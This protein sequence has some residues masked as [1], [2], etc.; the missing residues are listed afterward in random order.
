MFTW[1]EYLGLDSVTYASRFWATHFRDYIPDVMIYSLPNALWYLSGMLV[2]SQ[3]W[4]NQNEK[5]L[6]IGVVTAIA[7]GLEFGQAV[8]FVNGT[9]GF[10]DVIFMI[11]SIVAF[12]AL[13]ALLRERKH[14]EE[15]ESI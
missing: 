11:G 9:F 10:P 5:W 3:I 1:F 15:P 12:F 8:G 7:F 2:F 14:H 13:E 6:W 4:K